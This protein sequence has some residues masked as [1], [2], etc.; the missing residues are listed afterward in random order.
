MSQVRPRAA[1]DAPSAEPLWWWHREAFEAV[2][3]AAA[4]AGAAAARSGDPELGD[5]AIDFILDRLALS[6][7]TPSPEEAAPTALD[8]EDLAT[9][10]MHRFLEHFNNSPESSDDAEQLMVEQ[11]I[12][13]EAAAAAAEASDGA[14]HRG[15]PGPMSLWAPPSPSPTSRSRAGSSSTPRRPKP[16]S[17]GAC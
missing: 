16:L 4:A 11:E 13:Q 2:A 10:Q 3:K 17:I 1:D 5:M 7:E 8:P 6:G 14:S 12:A 9:P 15:R